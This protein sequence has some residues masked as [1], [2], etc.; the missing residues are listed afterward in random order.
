MTITFSQ[1]LHTKHK[2][3]C[4]QHLQTT[5]Q[6][7][8]HSRG[9]TLQSTVTIFLYQSALFCS[10]MSYSNVQKRAWFDI[11]Q[12]YL[13]FF[14]KFDYLFTKVE[15]KQCLLEISRQDL[16][17]TC[18]NDLFF[19]LHLRLHRFK[20]ICVHTD[21]LK[22]TQNAVVHIPGLEVALTIHQGD[23]A[24]ALSL[25]AVYKQ[26]V[27][28][29]SE[30]KKKETKMASARKP[31]AFVWTVNEVKLLLRLTL[32]YKASKLQDTR[33]QVVVRHCC[34]CYEALQSSE[35]GGK[36]SRSGAMAS[37]FRKVCGFA[38]HTT[39]G[40]LRFQDPCGR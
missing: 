35:V 39:T 19:F 28:G 8:F 2:W 32:D 29:E 23:G 30:N 12:I 1:F 27:E 37:S 21:P 17:H 15:K 5:Y 34:C 6:S 14:L 18:Q 25:N 3:Q 7:L 36:R 11:K 24:C 38:V 13:H 9:Y 10:K 22:T 26:T 31:E 40:V 20:N 33:A 16:V 4:N